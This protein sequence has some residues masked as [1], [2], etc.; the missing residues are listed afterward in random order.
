[1][2]NAP[3]GYYKRSIGKTL[4][5]I[6]ILFSMA[7]ILPMAL[8]GATFVNLE[9]FVIFVAVISILAFM[10]DVVTNQKKAKKIKRMEY[11]LSCP[12]VKG[13]VI[14]IKRIPYYF[15]KEITDMPKTRVKVYIPAKNVV[16]RI[17][18]R[19]HNPVTDEEEIAISEIYNIVVIKE[20]KNNTVVVHYSPDGDIWIEVT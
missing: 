8:T 2:K 9:Y 6:V 11:L 14:E 17:C 5:I 15:G 18:A 20:I 3:I 12:S 13:E 10:S 1:M 16:Y 4:S 7:L 19:F